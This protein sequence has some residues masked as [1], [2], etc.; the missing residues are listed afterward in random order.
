MKKACVIGH[1][2]FGEN[3]LNGQTIKTKNVTLELEKQFGE[4]KIIKIDTHGGIKLLPNIILKMFKAFK[5]SENIIIFPAHNGVRVFVPLCNIIN[6]FFRRKL[7]YIVIGG[8]LPSFLKNRS[9]LKWGLG[10]FYCIY[11]ETG[12]MKR[13]LGKLGLNNITILKNFKNFKILSTSEL[14]STYDKPYKICTFSRVMKEKGIED[15]VSAVIS[16][17]KK[18]RDKIYTLD[19]Y[20]QVD[21]EQVEWFEK[22]KKS[23]PD[24]ISYKGVVKSDKSVEVLKNYFLLV[25]PT[26]FFTEGIPGTILDAYAAGV[27]VLS[28]KWESFFDVVDDGYTGIGYEF[29]DVKA[30][31]K[32]LEQISY[33]PENIIEKKCKCLKKANEYVPE[34]A[35]YSLLKRL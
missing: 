1:F 19:I 24:Y 10:Q 33:D 11:V 15:I 35:I 25:F 26:R 22:V 23:F 3:L 20:G 18:N 8:W 31:T 9:I 7:H 21:T 2:G 4:D 17:N 16:I 6:I 12:T 28:S 5:Y 27:P 13:A 30:L 29:G 32:I 14:K 34:V